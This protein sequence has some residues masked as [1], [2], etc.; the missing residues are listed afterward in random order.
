MKAD[1]YLKQAWPTVW[2]TME[3]FH[4]AGL[5]QP[6]HLVAGEDFGGLQRTLKAFTAA[7]RCRQVEWEVNWKTPLAPEL[8]V[9]PPQDGTQY[10]SLELLAILRALRYNDYFKSVSFKD[11]DLSS[12]WGRFDSIRKGSIAYMNR[13][14][15]YTHPCT[16]GRLS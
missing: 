12:L 14:C 11:V 9:V 8:R 15:E 4:I 16:F 10:S 1:K 3:V 13:S 2:Q 7:Y 6:Q 5:P